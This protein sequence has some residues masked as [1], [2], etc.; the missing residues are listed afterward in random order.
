MLFVTLLPSLSISKEFKKKCL[1]SEFINIRDKK[2]N[3]IQGDDYSRTALDLLQKKV[4]SSSNRFLVHYD[5]VGKHAP[6]LVDLNKNNIPDYIDSVLYYFEY[7]YQKEVVEMGYY[8]PIPDGN[9]SGSNAYDIYICELGVIGYYGITMADL[10]SPLK[11]ARKNPRYHSSIVVDNNYSP[12]DTTLNEADSSKVQSYNET[13]I[14]GLRITAVHEFHHAIQLM[15][16][17]QENVML[18]ELTSTSLE[19]IIFPDSKDNIKNINEMFKTPFEFALSDLDFNKGYSLSIFNLYLS[20]A[21]SDSIIKNTWERMYLTGDE[22][23]VALDSSCIKYANK[24]LNQVWCDFMPWL[25]YTNKRAIEGKYFKYAK[26]YPLLRYENLLDTLRYS[27]NL[28]FQEPINSYS[29]NLY[30]YGFSALRKIFRNNVPYTNDTLDF[31]ACYTNYPKAIIHDM[32]KTPNQLFLSSSIQ[33]GFSALGNTDYFY[34]II[35][36]TNFC[37]HTY[38]YKGLTSNCISYSAPSPFII[39]KDE[40]IT[41]NIP[42]SA[43]V[44][45]KEK[46]TLTLYNLEMIPFLVENIEVT[47][48][49]DNN[50]VGIW[51]DKNRVLSSGVYIYSLIYRDDTSFGK[52]TVLRK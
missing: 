23:L 26:E 42:C 4:F 24:N 15:Y 3:K 52:I 30:P 21:Y 41:F 20:E 36:D 40:F 28:Y 17:E 14:R 43:K 19:N 44:F 7:A 47:L 39:D 33:N 25:Y 50:R 27:E 37:Y 49:K 51:R 29:F 35:A 9:L 10:N 11:P 5:T 6:S 34:K 46:P 1:T 22:S 12:K 18:M 8:S 2:S 48:D 38:I 16:A 45:D 13:G 32:D 31:V